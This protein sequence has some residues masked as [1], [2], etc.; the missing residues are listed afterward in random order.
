MAESVKRRVAAAR[1]AVAFAAAGT[2]A[3]AAWAQAGPQPPMAHTSASDYLLKA[4]SVNSTSILNGSLLFKDFKKGQ[5]P[6][7][8]AF[9]KLQQ[10]QNSFKKTTNAS[11]SGIKGELATH[12]AQIDGIKGELGSFVK[13]S[14]ADSRYVKVTDSIVRG[15]GSV[16]TASEPM[17]PN[18]QTF[19]PLLVTPGLLS[20]DVMAQTIRITNTSGEDLGHTECLDPGGQGNLPAGTLKAGE[21]IECF[22]D[23]GSTENIQFFSWGRGLTATL[24]AS[25]VNDGQKAQN[26]VQIL[27][28]L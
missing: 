16:F 26:T 11:I 1:L 21:N 3:G 19:T 14:D 8:V 5:V 24:S 2:I 27:I 25:H 17:D 15:D 9:N 10:A 22:L 4:G 7:A 20:V 12:K 23:S 13:L 18:S 28:G 6:S